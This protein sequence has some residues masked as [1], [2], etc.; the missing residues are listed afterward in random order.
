MKYENSDAETNKN[1]TDEVNEN[2]VVREKTPR[3]DE[4]TDPTKL[5]ENE[6]KEKD[7]PQTHTSHKTKYIT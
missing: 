1:K 7:K 4:P 2:D 6:E 3:P 5:E